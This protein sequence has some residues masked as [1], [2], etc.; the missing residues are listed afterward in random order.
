MLPADSEGGD[1]PPK[2]RVQDAWAEVLLKGQASQGRREQNDLNPLST[3]PPP[4]LATT[5]TLVR[6]FGRTPG[7]STPTRPSAP[8]V[9]L[10]QDARP[11]SQSSEGNVE[12]GAPEGPPKA[13]VG[14]APGDERWMLDGKGPRSHHMTLPM[15]WHLP[16]SPLEPLGSD[17]GDQGLD[18]S[19]IATAPK[20][21][22]QQR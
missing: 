9:A 8:A 13:S 6:Y 10:C 14:S 4:S 15:S 3:A 11:P 12:N 16:G 21:P 17:A 18:T 20:P 5:R 2:S 7:H 1:G 22:Q 19:Q